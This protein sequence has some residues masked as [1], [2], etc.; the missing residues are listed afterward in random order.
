MNILPEG[1]ISLILKFPFFQVHTNFLSII[2]SYLSLV[3]LKLYF[4]ILL[5]LV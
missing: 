1:K 4:D 5:F 3:F 2:Q